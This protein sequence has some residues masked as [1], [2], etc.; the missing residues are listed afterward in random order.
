MRW[1]FEIFI[2]LGLTFRPKIPN[3]A[4]HAAEFWMIEPEIA[5]ANLEDNMEL[6]E[7]MLKY[8]ISLCHGSYRKRWRFSISLSIKSSK[9]IGTYC[10]LRFWEGF[11][12][13][14]HRAV[15]TVEAFRLNIRWNGDVICRQSTKDISTERF[16][17]SRYL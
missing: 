5:F 14:S 16:L 1:P 6:A 7:D 4:R 8:I 12:Y 13:G 3:T 17:K 10:K 15:K 2:H 11:L 9:K